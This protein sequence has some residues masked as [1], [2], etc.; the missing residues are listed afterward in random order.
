LVQQLR[1]H[2]GALD[3]MHCHGT[4]LLIS[5][6]AFRRVYAILAAAESST[7]PWNL[8]CS[9]G[10]YARSSPYGEE[11]QHSHVSEMPHV[12]AYGR[13]GG[14]SKLSSLRPPTLVSSK[15]ALGAEEL[16]LQKVRGV[17]IGNTPREPEAPFYTPMHRGSTNCP[18]FM[19]STAR[20]SAGGTAGGIDFDRS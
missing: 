10:C 15:T 13:A 18:Y 1:R 4:R 6:L 20:A 17:P 3:D 9:A 12:R 2:K 16:L 7:K 14:P 8:R 19:F 5:G 11:G